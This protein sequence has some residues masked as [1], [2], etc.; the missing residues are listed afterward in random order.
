MSADVPIRPAA[1]VIVLRDSPAGPEVFMVRRHHSV[2][3]MAGAHVFPGGRVDEAD[4]DAAAAWCD[5]G[6]H[7]DA[8]LTPTPASF[9]AAA[10]ELFEEAGVL[11]ARTGAGAFVSFAG[12]ADHTR[13]EAYR[14][15]VH[16]GRRSLRAVVER[17][18]LRLALDALVPY[19]LWVTPPTE[20]R[21]FDTWFF[22]ARVPPEQ[23]P[24]HEHTESIDST[25]IA[26]A[27]AL[28]QAARGEM[29]LPPPTWFT[30]IELER[31]ASVSAAL[32]WASR[33]TIQ[34]RQPEVIEAPNGDRTII[35][36]TA[37]AGDD[38]RGAD[39]TRFVWRGDRW[40]PEW[41]HE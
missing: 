27:A 39:P 24:A 21:R 28:A 31:F 6:A 20:V 38:E 18:G 7:P 37:A 11:L 41:T 35:L 23:R 32:A 9:V 5:H 19:A 2:A 36:P 1:T 15:D 22:L 13:F 3:F 17:E 25:W 10:R 33:R 29:L 26:P 16:A 40:H 12:A 30:L 4:R 8:G 34:R 14:D